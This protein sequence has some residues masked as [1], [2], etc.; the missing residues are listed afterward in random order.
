MFFI[1]LKSNLKFDILCERLMEEKMVYLDYSA[2]TPVDK[3]VLESFDK[4]CLLYVG[5]PNSI[6]K[7]GVKAKELMDAATKQVST[8]MG[9]KENEVIFTS[10]ATESNNLAIMGVISQYKDRGKTIIT[11]KL[12]HSSILSCANYLKRNGYTIKYVKINDDG[13]V[14]IENL[15]ELID[16]DTILVSICEVNSEIGII[17]DVNL[18]GE[19]LKEYPRI[20]FHVDGTQAVGKKHVNLTNIDLYSFSAH[21]IYGIKGIGCLIKKENIELTPIIHGGKS[22]TIYRAGTPSLPLIV[23]FA[24]ALKLILNDLDSN[25]EYVKELNERLK[26]GLE[27]IKAVTINSNENC[28]YNIV[29]VSIDNVKPE[30]LLHA[31]EE[32]DIFISTKT[33][34]SQS[35]AISLSV[36]TLTKSEEKAKSSIRISLSHLTNRNEIDYFL[37]KFKIN[38]EKL[39]SIRS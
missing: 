5:N 32:D 35:D 3:R 21:K 33:A 16:D 34:C 28:L 7:E 14:D 29:N 23:S 9:V 39:R 2:T 18:I 13:M 20:I 19:V 6:H 11:T 31:L 25:I 17:Q 27:D 10:G 37:E 36:Y 38:V 4:T 24:K 8:L 1:V 22:Q 26:K 30:T 12:E 15:K